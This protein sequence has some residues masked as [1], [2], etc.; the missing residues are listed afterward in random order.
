MDR[1]RWKNALLTGLAARERNMRCLDEEKHQERKE[2]QAAN[3]KAKHSRASAAAV[4]AIPRLDY[5]ATADAAE[6][7]DRKPF[8]GATDPLS[9]ETNGCLLR[10]SQHHFL[11]TISLR[12]F[13][14][15]RFSFC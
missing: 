5:S 9:S 12:Q 1:V 13:F 15:V 10:L 11:E 2:E 14:L 7:P 3:L 8:T 4:S 6:P